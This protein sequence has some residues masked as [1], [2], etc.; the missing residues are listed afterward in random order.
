MI[1]DVLLDSRN[2]MMLVIFFGVVMWF[3]SWVI[4]ECVFF[5][6][7]VLLNIVMVV[8]CI[9]VLMNVGS[10]V[11][12][13]MFDECSLV[14]VMWLSWMMLVFDML[15]VLVLFIVIWFVNDDR[16]IMVFLLCLIICG[17]VCLVYS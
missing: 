10:S 14:V 6:F 8:C 17:V 1:I 7:R 9:G 16:L 15:Y 13:W 12:E 4:I 5:V 11:L 2:I 3:C